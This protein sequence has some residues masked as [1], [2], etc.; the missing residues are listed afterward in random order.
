[1]IK[2]RIKNFKNSII[3]KSKEKYFGTAPERI[4]LCGAY[5]ITVCM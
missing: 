3:I 4:Q 1:M 5:I 2:L